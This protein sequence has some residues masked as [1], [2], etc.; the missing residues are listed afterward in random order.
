MR[1]LR[2]KVRASS[3]VGIFCNATEQIC[4]APK[5]IEKKELHAIEDALQTEVLQANIASSPLL[6]VLAKGVGK[7]FIVPEIV[8]AYEVRELNEAGLKVKIIQGTYALGNLIALNEKG[9]AFSKIL[10]EKTR[11]DVSE[12]FGLKGKAL[13]VA[14]TELVGSCVVATNK[15]FIVNPNVSEKEVKE[16]KSILKVNGS[17]TSANY[18]D[19]FVGNSV[20]AN[21]FGAMVGERTTPKETMRIDEAF[22]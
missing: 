7:K 6:G 21:S 13:S 2:G 8:E 10:G 4:L 1:I 5:G 18:G 12:F 17:A 22:G 9:I 3:F 19:L 16:L 15:G 11:K 20:I 14:G